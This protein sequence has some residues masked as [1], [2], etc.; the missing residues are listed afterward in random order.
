MIFIE[1][2]M[3]PL[4]IRLGDLVWHPAAKVSPA[5]F[6][7]GW[8][9]FIFYFIQKKKKTTNGALRAPRLVVVGW[10]LPGMTVIPGCQSE[11]RKK[12]I[13]DGDIKPKR[14]R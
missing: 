12:E 14:N 1:F 9:I 3:A 11:G 4:W 2:L 10:S 8:Q 7:A 13:S 5:D 6:P